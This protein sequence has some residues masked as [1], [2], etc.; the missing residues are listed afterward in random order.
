[1]RGRA[2]VPCRSRGPIR[3]VP[4]ELAIAVLAAALGLAGCAVSETPGPA[5]GGDDLRYVAL[6]DSY[7]IGTSVDPPDRF[8]DQ[9]VVALGPDAPTLGLVANLGVNGYTS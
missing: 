8:P 5:G 1:M 7:T 2:H 6:G 4:T 3:M 9:L